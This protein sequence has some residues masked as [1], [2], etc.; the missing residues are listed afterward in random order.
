MS[1]EGKLKILFVSSRNA[2]KFERHFPLKAKNSVELI[3][4]CTTFFYLRK[5]SLMFF[6]SCYHITQLKAAGKEIETQKTVQVMNGNTILFINVLGKV[7]FYQYYLGS[8]RVEE[9]NRGVLYLKTVLKSID[10]LSL[11]CCMAHETQE[12]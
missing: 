8:L 12:V 1:S 6:G 11:K 3:M 7:L 9:H 4:A 2:C 10:L 5:R